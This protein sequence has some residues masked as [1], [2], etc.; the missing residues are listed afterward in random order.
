MAFVGDNSMRFRLLLSRKANLLDAKV[1][2]SSALPRSELAWHGNK[3]RTK[4]VQLAAF[5]NG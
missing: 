1:A 5:H 4:G 3:V 2:V